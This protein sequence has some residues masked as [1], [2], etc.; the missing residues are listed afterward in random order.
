MKKIGLV[1]S[2]PPG[3]SETFFNSK[4]KGLMENGHAV[5][6]FTNPTQE[7]YKFCTHKKSPPVHRFLLLQL[8]Q[9]GLVG[10]Q[11]LPYLNAVRK[12]VKLEL[13]NGTT[14]KRTLEKVYL[15]APL[16]KFKGDWLH[17]G[18]ATTAIDRELIALAIGA[19]MAV[20]FRGYDINVYPL[21]HHHCY[22]LIWK[23]VDKVHAIS[24]YLLEKGYLL[25]LSKLIPTQIIPPAVDLKRLPKRITDRSSA[26]LKILTIARFNWMKGIDY[27]IEVATYLKKSN[28]DFEWQLIG[29]GPTFESE[30]YLYHI[31]EA[32]LE[33]HVV[34]KGICSHSETLNILATAD[35]Y[36]QTSLNEGFCNAV[37][38]AQAIGIPCVAFKVGGLPENIDAQKTGWLIPPYD[39]KAMA[40]TIMD[41]CG[42][43]NADKMG[44]SERAIKRVRE[45]FNLESQKHDF[46]EFYIE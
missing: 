25:G 10:V 11:L 45:E 42:L 44:L 2:E 35:V 40:K 22:D 3:Y 46:H 1:L 26:T 8:F 6:L 27:L 13:Q 21:K 20:S 43:S 4:I 32:G 36:V 17:F 38:E 30:R 29:T 39:V 5:T 41:V 34:L 9:M 18:F 19:K 28:L 16:L 33:Q 14:L 31:H 24:K 12:F 37:L 15:N 7:T 23:R